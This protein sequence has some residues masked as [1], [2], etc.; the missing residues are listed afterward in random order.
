[1]L[2]GD[3]TTVPVGQDEVSSLGLLHEIYL[4]LTNAWYAC[5]LPPVKLHCS[6]LAEDAIK[7]VH[8]DAP[9]FG[10]YG[11]MMLVSTLQAAVKNVKEKRAQAAAK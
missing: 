10:C 3:C 4:M 5:S 6:M 11:S 9:W 8:H 1:M 2:A 7:E